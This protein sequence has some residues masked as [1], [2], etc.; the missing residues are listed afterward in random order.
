MLHSWQDDY[1]EGLTNEMKIT[2]LIV[3]GIITLMVGPGAIFEI[4]KRRIPKM[5]T[6]GLKELFN[7]K[8]NYP[9]FNLAVLELKKRG[10]DISFTFPAFLDLALSPR[11]EKL[12]GIGNLNSHFGEKLP[13][14]NLS[15]E[16]LTPEGRKQLLEVKEKLQSI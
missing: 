16:E 15:G 7:K 1:E 8:Y 14:I 11:V 9:Y 4:R 12:I 10:E 3:I 13:H 6:E 5:S 2:A